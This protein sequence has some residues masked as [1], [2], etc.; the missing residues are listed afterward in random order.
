MSKVKSK[1]IWSCS[2]L[3][4]FLKA[5]DILYNEIKIGLLSIVSPKTVKEIENK[6]GLKRIILQLYISQ[7]IAQKVYNCLNILNSK[8]KLE[9]IVKIDGGFYKSKI[10]VFHS[11]RLSSYL[12]EL[13]IGLRSYAIDNSLKQFVKVFSF[14]KCLKDLKIKSVNKRID[15]SVNQFIVEISSLCKTELNLQIEHRNN[16]NKSFTRY[17]LI[18]LIKHLVNKK[19]IRVSMFS[20][21]AYVSRWYKWMNRKL[22]QLLYQKGHRDILKVQEFDRYRQLR[23]LR[24]RK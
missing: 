11:L 20:E 5:K 23:F 6:E 22:L 24:K 1:D 2:E 21:C 19:K 18:D 13:F 7:D 3:E 8:R 15:Y 14:Y 10:F 9:W 12:V 17:M 4:D 16:D